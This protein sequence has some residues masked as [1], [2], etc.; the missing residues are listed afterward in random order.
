MH[1][2]SD[3]SDPGNVFFSLHELKRAV[4]AG[5]NTTPGK[6]RVGYEMLK[7]VS[8]L[9]LDEILALINVVWENGQ[10]PADWKHAVVVPI[11]NPGN[12][13]T[14][15]GS[16]RPVVLTSVLCKTMERMVTNRLV[17]MLERRD[18]FSPY[19]SGFRLGRSTMDSV[20][21]LDLDVRRALANKEVVQQFSWT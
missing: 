5:S 8:D 21:M 18:F 7:H 17:H 1:F 2:N 9:V 14:S 13:A 16:Y 20:L 11:L 19:Q 12:V 10:F 6:D 15:P 3:N 4:Q